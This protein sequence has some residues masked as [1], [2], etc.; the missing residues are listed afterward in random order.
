LD[1]PLIILAGMLGSGCTEIAEKLSKRLG[2]DFINS[3][4]IIREIVSEGKLSYRDLETMTR[5]GEIDLDELIK[6]V[7]LDHVNKRNI[8]VEGRSAF[9]ILDRSDV[10]LKVLFWSPLEYRIKHIA[11]RRKISLDEAKNHVK[12]GDEDRKSLV[13][14]LYNRNWLDADL[15]DI[16][17][18]TSKWSSEEVAEIIE[19]IYRV[20]KKV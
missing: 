10:D 2:I 15:Y 14:R 3:G 12:I 8:I 20:R 4:K 1:K 16:V 5:S 18:N 6:S 9:L 19:K 7:L 13:S 11:G 17:I